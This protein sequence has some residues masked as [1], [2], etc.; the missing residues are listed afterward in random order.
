MAQRIGEYSSSD[1]TRCRDRFPVT[2]RNNLQRQLDYGA[3]AMLGFN[4]CSDT[5]VAV[6]YVEPKT[7][8]FLTFFF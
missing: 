2:G 6:V 4:H 7:F 5:K 3:Y 8:F 1:K